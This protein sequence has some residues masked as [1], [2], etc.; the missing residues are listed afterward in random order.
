MGVAQLWSHGS[1]VE[2][3]G[4]T[5]WVTGVSLI[6][7]EE[8]TLELPTQLLADDS[9]TLVPAES[10]PPAATALASPENGGA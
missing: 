6:E 3:T 10:W 5:R 2:V 1:S 9:G 4:V 7:M 8:P